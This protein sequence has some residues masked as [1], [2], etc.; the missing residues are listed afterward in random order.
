MD[1]LIEY[2]V[3]H[4]CQ[5]LVLSTNLSI[6]EISEACGFQNQSNFNRQFKAVKGISPS[7]YKK[8]F[9]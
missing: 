8:S 7:F 2:R 1:F 4:A 3:S 9:E 5:Q 6:G